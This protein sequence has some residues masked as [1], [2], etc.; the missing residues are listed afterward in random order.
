MVCAKTN[1]ISGEVCPG[2]ATFFEAANMCA[3]ANVGGRLCTQNELAVD[4]AKGTIFLASVS[5]AFFINRIY[6]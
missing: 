3:N 6:Y 4:A 5:F 1:I 2:E